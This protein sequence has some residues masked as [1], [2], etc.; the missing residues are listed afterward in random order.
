MKPHRRNKVKDIRL[1]TTLRRCLA[2]SNATAAGR[3][4][5]G[6]RVGLRREEAVGARA[7]RGAAARKFARPCCPTDFGKRYFLRNFT[8]PHLERIKNGIRGERL[9]R[10]SIVVGSTA[11]RFLPRVQIGIVATRIGQA[12][13]LG[14]VG[15]RSAG[16]PRQRRKYIN[17]APP[18]R[19]CE[20]QH[21]QPISAHSKNGAIKEE[22]A[23]S[24]I[25]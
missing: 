11:L 21:P 22:K 10:Q 12:G 17:S 9:L 6:D 5:S 18:R 16:A 24:K 4:V 3:L 20:G 2:S 7:R 1:A 13:R 8:L 23:R 19:G 14:L 25:R 15:L